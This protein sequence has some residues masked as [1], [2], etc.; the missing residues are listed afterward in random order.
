MTDQQLQILQHS[1]GRDQYGRRPPTNPHEDYRNY[2]V[3]D[4]ETVDYPLCRALENMG[5]M[6]P[7]QP[8]G[9][10]DQGSV[11]FHVTDKGIEAVE[12][13]SPEPPKLSRSKQRYQQ[14]LDADGVVSFG[15]W[16]KHRMYEPYEN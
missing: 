6:R 11:V 14:Y 2:F 9:F 3:T 7:H 8:P 16:L 1:L 5:L 10:I 15:E 13:L 12:R 4:P